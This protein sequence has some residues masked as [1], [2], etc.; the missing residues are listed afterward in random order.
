M[1]S[2]QL[3]LLLNTRHLRIKD[4]FLYP[5]NL[6][7]M[8]ELKLDIGLQ[9]HSRWKTSEGIKAAERWKK[10]FPEVKKAVQYSKNDFIEA[11][12]FLASPDYFIWYGLMPTSVL[13]EERVQ[14]DLMSIMLL[15]QSKNGG[16]IHF[17]WTRFADPSYSALPYVIRDRAAN[18]PLN[19]LLYPFAGFTQD[20][21][22]TRNFEPLCNYLSIKVDLTQIP[23]EIP[24]LR[25]INLEEC[26]FNSENYMRWWQMCLQSLD[27]K[28]TRISFA[29]ISP[30]IMEFEKT[31][32]K[33]YLVVQ[34]NKNV[35]II[36]VRIFDPYP[37]ITNLWIDPIHRR[38]GLATATISEMLNILKDMNHG[39]AFT[40]I[41][42]TNVRT[43]KIAEK[44]FKAQR[45]QDKVV[46]LRS[47][48]L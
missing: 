15:N 44:S 16:R 31:K 6:V 1:S 9:S 39:Y 36:E 19:C 11:A 25:Q 27:S 26:L 7:D 38:K 22:Q 45:L 8:E 23:D 3:S 20:F 47:P 46:L 42:E 28:S 30:E 48:V 29:N 41:E 5:T 13:V 4:V 2:L 43:L 33:R 40:Y 21:L 10:I 17:L 35:G 14:S 37:F 34:D 12:S 32:V 18:A 24:D